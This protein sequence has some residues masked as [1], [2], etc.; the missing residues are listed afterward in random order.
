[1]A[2]VGCPLD[3]S[4]SETLEREPQSLTRA[5][6]HPPGRER[7]DARQAVPMHT[8]WSDEQVNSLQ[9]GDVM[10]LPLMVETNWAAEEWEVNVILVTDVVPNGYTAVDPIWTHRE[11]YTDRGTGP[12]EAQR[13]IDAAIVAFGDRLRAVLAEPTPPIAE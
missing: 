3:R 4:R 1:M 12:D 2:A 6:N 8:W 11:P 7:L 10:P 13:V 5:L 9:T